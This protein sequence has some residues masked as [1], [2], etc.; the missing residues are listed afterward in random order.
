MSEKISTYTE[1]FPFYLSEHSRPDTRALH[2]FGTAL[3]LSLFAAAVLTGNGW[4]I[5]AAFV[6]GYAFAF[7]A[8]ALFEKNR[9]AT[10]TYPV[11]SFFADFHMFWLWLTGQLGERLKQHNIT[12]A[13]PG[14][15]GA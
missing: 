10:F 13:N 3:G 8:H 6:S 11:W 12:P 14:G 1:F 4:L 5:L 9:P 2:Y 7:L 15:A